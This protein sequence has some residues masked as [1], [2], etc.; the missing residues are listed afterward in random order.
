MTVLKALLPALCQISYLDAVILIMISVA[1]KTTNPSLGIAV[2]DLAMSWHR[3]LEYSI[4]C[5]QLTIKLYRD[6]PESPACIF[7]LSRTL[8]IVAALETNVLRAFE[9]F[10]AQLN[11]SCFV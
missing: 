11:P 5:F 3:G 1:T 4:D 6:K 10:R 8:I 2:P 9:P 7:S